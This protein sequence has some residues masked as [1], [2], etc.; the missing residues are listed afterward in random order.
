M[1]NKDISESGTIYH[2][3]SEIQRLHDERERLDRQIG[4]LSQRR[5]EANI[6][7][8]HHV[9]AVEPFFE[10]LP[11]DVIIDLYSTAMWVDPKEGSC[12]CR[13]GPWPDL[14]PDAEPE[15]IRSVSA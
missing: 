4:D 8:H 14:V 3:L 10:K 15:P 9:A 2:H 12:L 13:L 11:G 1:P 5:R 7:Y 6:G